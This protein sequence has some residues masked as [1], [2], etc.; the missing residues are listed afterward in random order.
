MNA[1]KTAYDLTVCHTNIMA[2]LY[3][4]IIVIENPLIIIKLQRLKH[5]I[6]L[7]EQIYLHMKSLKHS[8]LK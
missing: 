3:V 2:T 8:S 4:T 5:S 6:Y 1:V 7:K